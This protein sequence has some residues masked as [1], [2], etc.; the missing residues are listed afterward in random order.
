VPF[1]N[2]A[3]FVIN[4]L[5]QLSGGAK[6]MDLR[7][8]GVGERRLTVLDDMNRQ[9]ETASRA[10]EA[11]FSQAIDQ[12]RSKIESRTSS[13]RGGAMSVEDAL[14][15]E[16][17]RSEILTLRQQLRAS[18]F[19]VQKQ[20][21]DLT[22]QIQAANIWAVPLSLGVILLVLTTWRWLGRRRALK[23]TGTAVQTDGRPV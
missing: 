7:G 23:L 17:L 11:E 20:V 6:M 13:R 14:E 9:A 19:D 21:R 1:A 22:K 15:I 4:A 12:L 18:Q 10:R 2:N 3:D 8:R 16:T 5:D